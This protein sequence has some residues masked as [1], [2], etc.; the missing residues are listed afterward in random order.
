MKYK[1][2]GTFIALFFYGCILNTFLIILPSDIANAQMAELTEIQT[3]IFHLSHKNM[4]ITSETFLTDKYIDEEQARYFSEISKPKI[5]TPADDNYPFTLVDHYILDSDLKIDYKYDN[6]LCS[7]LPKTAYLSRHNLSIED[8]TNTKARPTYFFIDK[9][10]GTN[11]FTGEKVTA[12]RLEVNKYEYFANVMKHKSV[13]PGEDCYI[14]YVS[15]TYVR[16]DSA[17]VAIWARLTDTDLIKRCRPTVQNTTCLHPSDIRPQPEPIRLIRLSSDNPCIGEPYLP[18]APRSK[19][20]Y[21]FPPE[22]TSAAATNWSYNYK[23][24]N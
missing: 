12:M 13:T 5:N 15:N 22:R 17:Q 9:M 24:R 8:Y 3:G 6:I 10:K 21:P 4:G 18:E 20:Y 1:L 19:C 2:I 14:G 23:L 11:P 7:D 16:V